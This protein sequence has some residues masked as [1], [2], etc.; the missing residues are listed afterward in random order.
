[1]KQ[2]NRYQFGIVAAALVALILLI[3]P[4]TVQ[5]GIY[6]SNSDV[7]YKEYWIDHKQ[8]TGGCNDDG[9]PTNP[10]GT[11]YIEPW[12]LNKCPKVLSFTIPDDFSAATKVEVYLDLWR[13]Y[14]IKAARFKLNDGPTEYAPNV[15]YDWSRTPWVG[16]VNKSELKQG[17][18]TITLYGE[19]KFHVHDIA[20]RIYGPLVAGPGSDVTPPNGQ[21]LSI[22]DDN[23]EKAANSGG[24]LTVNNDKLTLKAN[25]S[26]AKFVEFHAWYEGYDEDNDGVFR[27]WHNV[28]RNNWHPGGREYTGDATKTGGTIDHVGTVAVEN[29]QATVNWDVSHITN[30]AQMRFKIRV[31]DE[32]GNVRDAAGG[33]SATFKMMR[34]RPVLAYLVPDFDDFGLHMS[35]NRPDSVEYRFAMPDNI[36]SFNSAY[37]LGHYWNRPRFAINDASP[38]FISG[39]PDPWM[40][41]IRSFNPS[42][43]KPGI[44]RIVFSYPGSGSGQ[45]VEHPGPMF[46]VRKTSAASD[47]QAPSVSGQNPAPGATGVDEHASVVVRVNDTEYGVDFTTVRLRVN[48]T[49]V[50]NN[51]KIGGV[52]SSYILTYK[53]P[54]P[55]AYESTVNI[56]VEAC[57]LVNNCMNPV[58]YSFKI[59]E[60]DVTPPVISNV[61]VGVRPDGAKISWT[62]NEPATSRVDYGLTSGYELGN[63]S[64]SELVTQHEIEIRGLNPE[65]EYHFRIRS[66]DELNN[67]AETG[68][69]TFT[70]DAF[71]ELYSDDFN[72]CV[73]DDLLWETIDPKGDAAFFMNGEQLEI[74]VPGGVA[75]DFPNFSTNNTARI[76]QLAANDDFSLEVKFDSHVTQSVQMQGILIEDDADTFIRSGFE[77]T[78]NGTFNL[79]TAFFHNGT[80]VAQANQQ[81]NDAPPE[82]TSLY[83]RMVRSGNNWAWTYSYNGVNWKN[84][85]NRNFELSVLK[86]G[87]FAGNGGTSAPGHT[88]VVD[89]F[90]NSAEP[91]TPEDGQPITVEATAVGNGTVIVDP[92]LPKYTCGQPVA[93]SAVGQPGWSFDSW[94]GTVISTTNP[95]NLVVD[96][97]ENIIGTFTQDQYVLT[98]DMSPAAAAAGNTVTKNPNQPT[99]VYDDVVTLTA[100]PAPGWIFTGWGGALIGSNP[101]QS[102][103]MRQHETVVA[104]FEPI[105]YSLT[106]DIV[107]TGEGEGGTVTAD[108]QKNTYV[109]GDEVTLTANAKAG[110]QFVGWSG[111]VTGSNP[112]VTLTIT[113]HTQVTAEFRQGPFS[114]NVNTGGNGTGT[115]TIN[116]NRS[117]Y[118]YGDVVTLSATPGG[119]FFFGGWQGDLVGAEN[120]VEYTITGNTQITAIFTDNP[121]PTVNPIPDRTILVGQTITIPVQASDPD[122]ST[123]TLTADGLPRGASFVDNGDGTGSFTWTPGVGDRGEHVV[124]FIAHD[125]NGIGVGSQTVIITVEGYALALPVVLR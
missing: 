74:T 60:K 51:T 21:L 97:P 79:Y 86:V 102:I 104:N 124:T 82:V 49:D 31:V 80:R 116:P 47:N 91:I 6:N 114:L 36:N 81:L 42:V 58:N 9:S 87:V 15:G 1:M 89:Y 38:S 33:Q 67:V 18:N 41:Q 27:D 71:S 63:E 100:N 46:I 59:E 110:W 19:Q 14:D 66:A 57:D 30:Q 61:V 78:P 55:F 75:H 48:G 17:E 125:Q 16:E 13:N 106:I 32:H 39:A 92:N 96:G 111:A 52:A 2:M 40:L 101:T 20:I 83:L 53:P 23:G 88:A 103:T 24:T 119:G 73:L 115:V 37:L 3:G 62:T 22:A 4:A 77:R 122:G 12:R 10:N 8:F 93:L 84:G 85:G 34:N 64:D 90:F 94:S 117:E 121:P 7:T 45:F 72:S 107:S 108:P 76:M 112:T 50:T 5:A 99:Y 98:V 25:V 11:F 68:D 109:Y 95:L 43:F 70:T 54:Q 28:G 29:G 113:D 26:D 35:G 105:P 44:N 123:P 118:Y 65:T 120:P 56:S 69:N